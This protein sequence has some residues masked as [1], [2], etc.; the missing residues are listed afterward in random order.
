MTLD[1]NAS[2]ALAPRSFGV[3]LK[4]E[5][6]E[7]IFERPQSLDFFEI[8]AE[9]YMNLGGANRHFL[10]KIREN[11]AVSLH[12]VGLSLGAPTPL[13]P[14]RLKKL[15]EVAQFCA[16][17]LISEHLAWCDFAGAVFPDLLPLP[18]DD[19]GLAMTA[20]KI[21]QV[22]QALGRK[23]LI[24]NPA[25]Y[26]RFCGDF[27]AE[28]DFLAALA[29]KTG[30][31]L[32]LDVNN[33]YV[34]ATNHGFDAA[35]YLADFPVHRVE[36]IHL[37]GF[38]RAQDSTGEFLIDSHGAPVDPAVWA[39]Y[40]QCL[41]QGGP[42]PSLLEWDNCLPPWPV[43]LGEMAIARAIAEEIPSPLAAP[44]KE[45]RPTTPDPTAAP[46]T[47]SQ[48][49][50]A[51]LRDPEQDIPTFLR[52]GDLEKRFAV[53]RN[54]WVVAAREALKVNFPILLDMLGDEAF[55]GAAAEFAR[56]YPPKTPILGEYGAEF[57]AFLEEFLYRHDSANLAYLPD[58]GRLD[59]A[60][61]CAARAPEAAPAPIDDLAR[62]DPEKLDIAGATPH[63]SARLIRS[64]WPLLALSEA[65]SGD[66]LDWRGENLLI[67]RPDQAVRL[68]KLDAAAAE[69]FT[70]CAE[71]AS[72]ASA[73]QRASILDSAFDFGAT[74]VDLTR[75][76]AFLA[77]P[78]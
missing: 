74:L 44:V 38:S 58:L 68:K 6:A 19:A 24:E 47:W 45:R 75:A 12:G 32:L 51:A 34:S 57:P 33:I 17:A 13:D 3:G 22:Q 23:I 8:H 60:R 29:Q 48:D 14:E 1:P 43:L 54:N 4:P 31:G 67:L 18:Y 15:V 25:S 9:N 39:L 64:A 56:K 36:E 69:F 78:A 42:K 72:L 63:P 49:F 28:T 40:R 35:A 62:L 52:A 55:A 10:A 61:L 2:R 50:A 70:A 11:Y 65:K 27:H 26:L 37:A 21:E 59:W 41:E 66:T 71:K 5:H 77:F 46:Q 7:A 53:H 73:A 20:Q 76:G 30:C 16:P